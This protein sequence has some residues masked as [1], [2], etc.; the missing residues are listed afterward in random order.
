V[1][2][3]CTVPLHFIT[4]AGVPN[5]LVVSSMKVLVVAAVVEVISVGRF[6]VAPSQERKLVL[7][8]LRDTTLAAEALR[9][10]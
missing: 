6:K 5:T 8:A 3:D 1:I 7:L 10:L 2:A 4:K 9:V